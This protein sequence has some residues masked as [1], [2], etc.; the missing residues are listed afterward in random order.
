MKLIAQM[1]IT[2]QKAD[3]DYNSR[4]T[5]SWDTDSWRN[6]HSAMSQIQT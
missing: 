1:A 3:Q 4:T 2:K 5:E 6:F